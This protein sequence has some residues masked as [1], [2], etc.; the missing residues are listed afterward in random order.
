MTGHE[1]VE[2]GDH[3]EWQEV[4]QESLDDH[5]GLGIPLGE[6]LREG[7][8]HTDVSVIVQIEHPHMGE[9]GGGCG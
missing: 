3:D 7:I 5:V 9:E 6:V 1:Q 4:V 2:G 8:T